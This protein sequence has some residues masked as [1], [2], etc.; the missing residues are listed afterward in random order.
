LSVA[1][2]YPIWKQSIVQMAVGLDDAG[3]NISSE[4]DAGQ[5]SEGD[6]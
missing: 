3:K 5:D 6:V 1:G 2:Y 4:I